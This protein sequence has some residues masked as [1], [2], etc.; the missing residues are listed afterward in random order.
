METRA[1]FI[2]VGLFTILG[3]LGGLGFF[4]WLASVQIDRQYTRYGILFED[5]TGLDQSADVFFNGVNVGRVVGI[6]IWEIDPRMVYVGIEIDSDAP[7]NEGT[8]AQIE[9]LGVTGV[10]Y[11][12]LAGGP[13]GAGPLTR[14]ADGHA[15][16]PS[17]RSPMQSLLNSAPD[18]AEDAAIVVDQLR[19]MTGSENQ[20][21]LRNILQ[22][23]DTASQELDTALTDFSEIT[24]SIGDAAVQ[25]TDFTDQLA[26]FGKA[27]ERTLGVAD[28][29]MATINRTFENA[30]TA[31]SA[32]PGAIEDVSATLATIDEFINTGLAPLTDA[33]DLTLENADTALASMDSAFANADRIMTTDLGPVLS[34]ARTAFSE[35]AEATAGVTDVIPAIVTDLRSTVAEVRS[36]ISAAAPG[37]RDFGQLGGEARALI[38]SINALVQQISR[39]PAGFVLQNPVPDYR[40]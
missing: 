3:I 16:I 11:I 22:N 18:L 23:I 13:P 4:I 30:D 15:L 2:L 12:A 24:T 10:A 7:V 5:V 34:D 35:L 37:M 17:R 33:L 6:R 25:I 29:T 14:S 20:A 21:L 31:I 27:T 32:L 28:E 38:R 9:S 26:E 8:V 36:A 19:E 39:D 1:H 40:R